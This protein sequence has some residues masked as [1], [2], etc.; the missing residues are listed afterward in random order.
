[1][2]IKIEV[3]LTYVGGTSTSSILLDVFIKADELKYAKMCVLLQNLLF[4]SE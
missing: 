4:V 3:L 1:M 2:Q